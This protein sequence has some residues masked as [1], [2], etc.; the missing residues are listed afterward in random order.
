MF[1]RR[2]KGGIAAVAHSNLGADAGVR[3]Y[4][5]ADAKEFLALMVDTLLEDGPESGRYAHSQLAPRVQKLAS[6][7]ACAIR[8]YELPDSHPL[9]SRGH[10]LDYRES[11]ADDVVRVA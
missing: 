4:V 7:Q 9:C 10:P 1:T 2:I 5:L 6:G 8:R 11:G 3:A